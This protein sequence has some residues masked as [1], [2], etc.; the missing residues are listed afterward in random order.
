[1]PK[2]ADITYVF[3]HYKLIPLQR[4][5][6]SS[7]GAAV[8]LTVKAFDLLVLLVSR[9]QDLVTKDEIL[10]QVWPDVEI[11][12]SN[13]T[14]TISMIRRAL[15]E[16]TEH[17]YIE[18]VTK[19]GYRFVATVATEEHQSASEHVQRGIPRLS[20]PWIAV[21]VVLL[22][23]GIYA[24]I[25]HH[26]AAVNRAPDALMSRAIRYETQGNDQL[27]LDTLN[28]LLK[29]QPDNDEARIK[30]AWL[31]HQDDR[32]DEASS[33]LRGLKIAGASGNLSA[34]M[35]GIQ[36][37]AEGIR[38]ALAENNNE[39][40]NKFKT[41]NDIDPTDI[42]ALIYQAEVA[43]DNGYLDVANEALDKCLRMK[44][45]NI[46]CGYFRIQVLIYAGR[47]DDALKEY[48]R[49]TKA[50]V[51]YPWFDEMAGYAE[52]AKDDTETAKRDFLA[53][54]DASRRFN[55]TVHFRA[56]QDGLA[57]VDIYKG[58]LEAASAQLANALITSD[59]AYEQA[60]YYIEMARIESLHG[61]PIKAQA[62]LRKAA[63]LSD[64]PELAVELAKGFAM[65]G[66]YVDARHVL[67][68]HQN[69]S[70]RLGSEYPAAAQ[71]VEGLESI[72]EQHLQKGIDLLAG[73]AQENPNPLT[74]YYLALAEMQQKY[75]KRAVQHLDGIV[76]DRGT[77]VLDGVASLIPLSEYNLGVC[78]K[79][80]GKHPE[81]DEH[82]ALAL[83]IWE[84]ADPQL[85]MTMR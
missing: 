3:G 44:P 21:L 68:E 85:K 25:R 22:A 71:F 43:S 57:A 67:E 72:H 37:K 84:D 76:N 77:V 29:E 14:T 11:A 38:L 4:R 27:A 17:A 70:P 45:V 34:K 50:D 49:L 83:R 32:D 63:Q 66:D 2:E 18:T 39:A 46:E 40:I 35:R 9:A 65:S 47:F 23:V 6:Y 20:T 56:A 52:L 7:D 24:G 26:R 5:L 79:A 80:T 62:D 59:S 64:S 54:N 61:K 51:G 75:W 74:T 10:N 82:R 16:D 41:A 58:K 36:L 78:L 55:S 28:E 1:M 13:I 60:D 8:E 42:N 53:L 73:S 69:D 81:A 33:Y 12:E 19:M 48:D 30:A 31:S 15:R